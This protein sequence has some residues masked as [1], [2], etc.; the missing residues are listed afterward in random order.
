MNA[1]T[2]T[3][4][5]TADPEKVELGEGKSLANFRIGNSEYV[6]G[7]SKDN[8]FFDVTAFGAQAENVLAQLKKGQRVIVTG[9]LQHRTYEKQ[10]GS[11]GGRTGLVAQAVGVSLEFAA[12]S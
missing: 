3:G 2:I 5:L 6:N 8:G 1:I 9:R 10:D 7:E 12:K 11:R 4:N